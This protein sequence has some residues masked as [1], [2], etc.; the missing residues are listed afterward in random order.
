MEEVIA[1]GGK[2]FIS[3]G[4]GGVLDKNITAGH[5]LVPNSA[6]RDE[7]TSYHYVEPGRE[8]SVNGKALSA[9]EKVLK[10]H[11]CNYLLVKTWLAIYTITKVK[12]S[13]YDSLSIQFLF[14]DNNKYP[15]E[16]IGPI[17]YE[18]TGNSMKIGSSSPQELQGVANFHTGSR[19]NADNVKVTFDKEIILTVKW[20]CKSETLKLERQN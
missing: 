16:K 17:E 14:D 13:Y 12:S 3:C 6:V 5:I 19:M 7:G 18:L 8:I 10:A 1:L 9:I 4:S 20:Q 11:N 15:T 2:K